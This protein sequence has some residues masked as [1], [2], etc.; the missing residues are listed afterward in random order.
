[1]RNY[2]IQCACAHLTNGH[3]RAR[4]DFAAVVQPLLQ[5]LRDYTG[6]YCTLIAGVPLPEGTQEFDLRV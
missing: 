2:S 6:L 1:M 3:H 4:T 5:L